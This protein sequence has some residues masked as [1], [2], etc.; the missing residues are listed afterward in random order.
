[1]EKMGVTVSG[2]FGFRIRLENHKEV[3]CL[4]VVKGLEVEAYAVKAIVDFHVMSTGL[5]AY[6]IILGRPWL[7][8]MSAIQDWRQGTISLYGKTEERRS[9]DMGSRKSLDVDLEEEDESS[10]EESSTMSEVDSDSTTSSD[11][12][13]NVAFL[14]V[15]KELEKSGFVAYADGVED[16]DEGPYEII[17]EL[18]QPKV[19]VSK[20]RD[21]MV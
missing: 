10:D 3:K 15:N 14:V 20:K 5:G 19:E 7:R 16:E 11:E 8:A 21:L 1:M 17:E 13:V 12:D 9:F 6:P 18:M 4:G 2:V